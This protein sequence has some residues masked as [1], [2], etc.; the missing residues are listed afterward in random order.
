MILHLIWRNILHRPL[1]TFISVLAV[2]VEVTLVLIIVGLT[3]G[4]ADD[5]GRRIE[6]IGADVMLQPP[7]ASMLLALGDEWIEHRA[8][9]LRDDISA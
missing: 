2:A 3:S 1:R 6:G 9:I 4:M 7:S 5:I 8:A